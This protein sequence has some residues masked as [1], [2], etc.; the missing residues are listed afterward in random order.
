MNDFPLEI[1]LIENVP[2]I[3][4]QI[5]LVGNWQSNNPKSDVIS[6]RFNVITWIL[7]NPLII[8]FL[9]KDKKV[10][11]NDSISWKWGVIIK[12]PNDVKSIFGCFFNGFF[13]KSDHVH[14]PLYKSV[15]FAF[16]EKLYFHWLIDNKMCFLY[17]G[18]YGT[19]SICPGLLFSVYEVLY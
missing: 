10:M 13:S 7:K 17:L 6:G 4:I 8:V 2:T 14:S 3:N 12:Y 19:N 15:R 16:L 5:Y 9:H 1:I 18:D 11:I